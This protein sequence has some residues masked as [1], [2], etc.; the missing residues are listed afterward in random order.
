MGNPAFN[1]N[2]PFSDVNLFASDR[3]LREAVARE[4]GGWAA[5]DL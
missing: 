5:Q 1:Q 2:P 4:G 3:V